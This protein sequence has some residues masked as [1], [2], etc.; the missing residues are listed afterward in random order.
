MERGIASS[1]SCCRTSVARCWRQGQ[2]ASTTGKSQASRMMLWRGRDGSAL[3][4]LIVAVAAAACDAQRNRKN[5]AERTEYGVCK[6]QQ[7]G[8]R[9]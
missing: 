6:L 2:T 1:A 9:G 4:H 8:V 3:V 7:I 5:A